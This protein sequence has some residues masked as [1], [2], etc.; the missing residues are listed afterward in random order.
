MSNLQTINSPDFASDGLPLFLGDQNAKPNPKFPE[1][2]WN[3]FLAALGLILQRYPNL[4]PDPEEYQL[5]QFLECTTL[6]DPLALENH[7]L[8]WIKLCPYWGPAPAEAWAALIHQLRPAGLIDKFTIQGP[9]YI[10][11][12]PHQKTHHHIAPGQAIRNQPIGCRA[13]ID[14]QVWLVC[15]GAAVVS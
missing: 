7:F 14:L 6:L 15:L 8:H 4:S 12:R 11:N 13:S 2:P 5:R 9:S 1:Y 3:I 10:P